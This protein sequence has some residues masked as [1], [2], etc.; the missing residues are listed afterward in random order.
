MRSITINSPELARE[1]GLERTQ[2]QRRGIDARRACSRLT[3]SLVRVVPGLALAVVLFSTAQLAGS[4]ALLAA[5]AGTS[6][7][8]YVGTA[9]V[10]GSLVRAALDMGAGVTAF[11]LAYQAGGY[12]TVAAAY[13]VH[14]LW[15]TV[16]S[17]LGGEPARELITNWTALNSTMALLVLIG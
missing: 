7:L 2:R 4:G 13:L 8:L 5:L 11:V 16:R 1:A 6:A 17:A 15:G 10:S 9:L 12:E 3:A 14:G